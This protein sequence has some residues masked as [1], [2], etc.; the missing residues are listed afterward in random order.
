MIETKVGQRR[1]AGDRAR[2]LRVGNESKARLIEPV[3]DQHPKMPAAAGGAHF[4]LRSQRRMPA[5][6]LQVVEP[7]ILNYQKP[8]FVPETHQTTNRAR[9]AF[10]DEEIHDPFSH[11]PFATADRA[12]EE[13]RP[14]RSVRGTVNIPR[15][16]SKWSVK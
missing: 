2:R 9:E 6:N 1:I 15:L 13:R 4:L 14:A 5:Q 7:A 8:A 16:A 3:G 10:W 11:A 12:L